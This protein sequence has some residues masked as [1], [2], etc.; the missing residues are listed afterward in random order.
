MLWVYRGGADW[1][2]KRCAP[3]AATLE[4]TGVVMMIAVMTVITGIPRFD[5][6]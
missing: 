1:T 5:K 6:K 3:S 4:G 2:E